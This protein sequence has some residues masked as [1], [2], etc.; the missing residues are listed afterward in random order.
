MIAKTF[1]IFS[2]ALLIGSTMSCTHK[3]N[4][5][6]GETEATQIDVG[7]KIPGRISKIDVIEGQEVSKGTVLGTLE[8]REVGAKLES[9]K[10][11]SSEAA[12]QFLLAKSTYD[13]LQN[14]FGSG[15]ITKQQLDEAKYK[16]EASRQKVLASKG[17][18]DEVEAYFDEATMKAPIDGEVVKIISNPGELVS[19]GYPVLTMI[20]LKDQW[21]TF[22]VR[23]D[24]MK[25]IKKGQQV[26]VEIPA[27]DKKVPMKITYISALGAF[28]RWKST[29]ESGRFDLKTFEVRARPEEP[30][31][32]FRPGMTAL[33]HNSNK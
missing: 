32:D 11:G 23:E 21:V 25:D 10:A 18:M 24:F 15:A 30:L 20:D 33:V 19:P 28:A 27:L 31:A 26:L 16:F 8:S 13:R 29:S 5:F 4:L 14:L 9:A 12:A 3:D 7:V 1:F 6:Y 17:T 2:L 22:N